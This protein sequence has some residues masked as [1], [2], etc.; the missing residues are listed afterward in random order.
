VRD[1]RALDPLRVEQSPDRLGR[2]AVGLV[3]GAGVDLERHAHV[4]LAEAVLGRADVDAAAHQP[5]RVR[6]P[7]IVEPE[8][9]RQ[10]RFAQRSEPVLA[11]RAVGQVG[12]ARP[13]EH[14]GVAVGGRQ[15]GFEVVRRFEGPGCD[16]DELERA[17]DPGHDSR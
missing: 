7:E 16:F 12:A 10:V 6:S 17:S 2:G 8:P 5:R 9:A 3:G 15:P 14:P 1:V 13:G 11:P 4:G